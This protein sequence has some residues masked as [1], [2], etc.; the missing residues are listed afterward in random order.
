M[1]VQARC[2]DVTFV[3]VR[4]DDVMFV[5]ARCGDVMFVLACYEHVMFVLACCEY[6]MFVL[7]CCEHV[8]FVLARCDDAMFVL[9]PVATQLCRVAV[10]LHSKL[11]Y[12]DI[13]LWRLLPRRTQPNPAVS[14]ASQRLSLTRWLS[15]KACQRVQLWMYDASTNSHLALVQ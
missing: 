10:S 2:E 15:N 12:P 1:F 3:L 6:V 14:S 13:S 7:A 5:L 8:M 11:I 9:A 4:C